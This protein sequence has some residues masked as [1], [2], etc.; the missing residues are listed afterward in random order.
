MGALEKAT[1][2]KNQGTGDSEIMQKL[3]GDGYSPKEI[4][5]S[6]SQLSIK[7]AVSD[8]QGG[9]QGNEPMQ[10]SIMGN[11]LS[12]SENAPPPANQ[13]PPAQN[14]M[15]Q[16]PPLQEEY[17]APAP[18]QGQMQQENYSQDYNPQY[19]PEENQQGY[20]QE[21][22]YD[23]NSGGGYSSM[24]TETIIEIAE[25]VFSE[26][27]KHFERKIKELTD[28]KTIY[29]TKIDDIN[30]RLRRI[31][32]NF[33]KMQTSIL[34]EIGSFGKNI[35][36]IKKEVAMVEDSFEKVMKHKK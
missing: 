16:N 9:Q 12:E 20:A 11:A 3:Q 35:S 6:M 22:Y 27:I 18:Q 14:Q 13:V 1:Q 23:Q 8:E 7:K 21:E 31:E 32:N 24:G 25:Q 28:F 15:Q 36:S 4:Q 10:P 2:L 26:K 19:P 29:Q 5:D 34:D 30:H 33:D 17:Y